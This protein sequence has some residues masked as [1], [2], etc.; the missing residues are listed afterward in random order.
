MIESIL[1]VSLALY[2]FTGGDPTDPD[3]VLNGM[4]TIQNQSSG[5]DEALAA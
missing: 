3:V 5:L 1:L 4:K 2:L